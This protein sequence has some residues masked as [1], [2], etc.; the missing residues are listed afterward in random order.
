MSLKK[1]DAV[2]KSNARAGST[3]GLGV[4]VN[5]GTPRLLDSHVDGTNR[6]CH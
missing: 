2:K 1:K 5:S 6:E 3:G 4:S